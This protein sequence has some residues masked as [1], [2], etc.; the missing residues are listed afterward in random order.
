[1]ENIQNEE[2]KK[3]PSRCPVKIF[4][5][6]KVK[7]LYLTKSLSTYQIAKKF[8][9]SPATIQNLLK[10][11]GVE[12]RKPGHRLK[13]TVLIPKEKWKIHYLAGILDGEGAIKLQKSRGSRHGSHPRLWVKNT[14]K[15]LVEWL[16][17]TF[18][19]HINFER[20]SRTNWSDIWR[21]SVT[22]TFDLTRLLP[23]VLPYLIVKREDAEK[24]LEF[25]KRR[26]ENS[27]Y[28]LGA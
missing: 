17:K 8:N 14:D 10:E 6:D 19:G 16:H 22:S 23:L 4:Y 27:G 28:R 24:V 21:W 2:M 15:K 11:E 1:M 9:C 5:R 18:G 13:K 25:C 26:L 3:L 12:L 20:R 7:E